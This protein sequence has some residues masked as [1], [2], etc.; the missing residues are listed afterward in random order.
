MFSSKL[1]PCENDKHMKP[2]DPYLEILNV[3]D[4][5]ILEV[6]SGD[7]YL[8][9]GVIP[10][11]YPFSASSDHSLLDPI[12]FILQS[13]FLPC[14]L[15]EA[16]EFWETQEQGM[17]S[18]GLWSEQALLK[19]ESYMEATALIQG[20]R[21]FLIIQRF[22]PEQIPLQPIL[23]K[24][25]EDHLVQGQER[26]VRKHVQAQLAESEHIRDEV[27]A[28]L[29]HL[30][31][32]TVMVDARGSITYV[33]PAVCDLLAIDSKAF[34]GSL[35]TD[36]LPFTE[37]QCQE[38]QEQ[39][40]LTNSHR[41]PVSLSL[42]KKYQAW[43]EIEVD[44]HDDPRDS[45]RIILFFQD[46]TEIE[47]LR[48]QLTGPAHFENLIG[49]SPAMQN[50][51]KK[52]QD[53]APVDVPVLIQG[54]T[55]TGKELVAKALH[56]L[57]VRQHKVFIAVN[58]AGLTDS[59]LGSQL[60]GHKRGAFTGAATDHEGFFE[61]ADGGIIFLDEIG[62]MPLTIQ[63][64]L[65]RVLQEGE[66]IRVGESRARKVDVRV[67]AATNQNL[68]DLVDRGAFRADLLYRIRVARLE[69]PPL[70]ERREDI[71]LLSEAFLAHARAITKKHD[72]R[73]IAQ[74]TMHTLLR[75]DWPGNIRELKGTFDYALIH[76]CG[77]SIQPSDLP[78]EITTPAEQM[79]VGKHSPKDEREEILSALEQAQ[80]KRSRAAKI[81][82]VSRSTLYR[83]LND[84]G[85]AVD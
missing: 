45:G 57:S 85:I 73:E 24:A 66:I 82:G 9:I 25:R 46:K 3:F 55:G 5:L 28:V 16:E 74:D 11:W 69:L 17:V 21:R 52:I 7:K 62:D 36:S 67:V 2:Q 81:L 18:S 71:P 38:V 43:L 1:G 70:R 13:C 47:S 39:I 4:A 27:M 51:Y 49:K 78:P 64:T 77:S 50:I 54:E 37:E 19:D 61:A 65:L 40:C 34:V 22:R 42:Q 35:W 79:R 72:V 83:R 26:E 80:G 30:Q 58:C 76:C 59:L 31:L 53:I 20:T 10:G 8:T 33:S 56:R 60:F 32:A 14:F 12:D 68:Q 41:S 63:T 48:R 23:Q 84:L 75:Y 15:I 6:E 44:V 29:D